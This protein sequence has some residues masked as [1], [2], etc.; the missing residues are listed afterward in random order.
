MP[1]LLWV[2]LSYVNIKLCYVTLTLKLWTWPKNT[3]FLYETWGAEPQ[4]RQILFTQHCFWILRYSNE[5]WFRVIDIMS[6]I[7]GWGPERG[8]FGAGRWGGFVNGLR[9][10]GGPFRTKA[11]SG[12]EGAFGPWGRTLWNRSG[13]RQK[14]SGYTDRQSEAFLILNES[15]PIVQTCRPTT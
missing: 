6:I 5:W 14:R 15:L 12:S 9:L 3:K 7:F 11:P 8:P 10:R 13:L 4:S 2:T 1:I